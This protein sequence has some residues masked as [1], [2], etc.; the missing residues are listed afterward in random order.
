MIGEPSAKARTISFREKKVPF[1]IALG[2]KELM[3]ERFPKHSG[4]SENEIRQRNGRGT[5]RGVGME[6]S[7]T[8]KKKKVW[9]AYHQIIKINTNEH[10]MVVF[11][12]I[13]KD[14]KE[15]QL[16]KNK[17]DVNN[18]KHKYDPPIPAQ[19]SFKIL[20]KSESVGII[21]PLDTEQMIHYQK[22]CNI[23]SNSLYKPQ[24][25]KTRTS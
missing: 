3:Q 1:T 23:T 4:N 14:C 6:R 2:N 12:N 10:K 11:Y 21:S 20:S 9:T 18:R 22:R 7:N 19:P 13:C 15:I 24:Q 5:Q 8:G 25:Y 16:T 17:M